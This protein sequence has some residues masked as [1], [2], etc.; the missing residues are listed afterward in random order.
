[1]FCVIRQTI[2]T[3]MSGDRQKKEN[4]INNISSRPLIISCDRLGSRLFLSDRIR[5]PLARSIALSIVM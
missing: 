5:R 2:D 1:M 3:V 4:I